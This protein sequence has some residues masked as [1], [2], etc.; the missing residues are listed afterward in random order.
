MTM[1]WNPPHTRP[2]EP[3]VGATATLTTAPCISVDQL[4]R[5]FGSTVAL[6]GVS[7]AID[8][9]ETVAVMGPSGSGKSTLAHSIAGLLL[10][11][12]GTVRLD[13]VELST[14]SEGRRS[15]LRL[16]RI[17]M[18]FQAGHLLGDVPAVENAA[19]GLMFAGMPRRQAVRTAAAWF[20]ALGLDGLERRRPGEL[21]GGQAQRV[22]IVRALAHQ[23]SVVIAD[24]PTAALDRATSAAVMRVLAD[25]CRHTGATLIV[26]THDPEVASVCSRRVHIVDGRVVADDRIRP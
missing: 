1:T 25:L 4:T 8:R 24:E 13:G 21:S 14:L 17:G 7:L 23:P 2:T 15:K 22:A 18:V 3:A 12:R 10:P 20:P 26:V 5:S 16:S 6:D 9:G 19:L 11:D